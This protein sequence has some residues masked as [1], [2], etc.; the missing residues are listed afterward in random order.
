MDKCNPIEEH[1]QLEV[2]KFITL[3]FSQS[4]DRELQT[5]VRAQ[6]HCYLTPWQI[7][8]RFLHVPTNKVPSDQR[9]PSKERPLY[10]GPNSFPMGENIW[11]ELPCLT[12]C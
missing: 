6:N 1:T 9:E 7:N 8:T 3:V 2:R 10:R 5:S 11:Y 4:P 12:N